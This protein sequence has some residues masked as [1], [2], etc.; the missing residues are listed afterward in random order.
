MDTEE[1]LYSKYN[2]YGDGSFDWQIDCIEKIKDL[3]YV[4]L[5]SSTG[6]GKTK[7]FLE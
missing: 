2:K 7:V 4:I 3:S 5:S 6:S 1:K